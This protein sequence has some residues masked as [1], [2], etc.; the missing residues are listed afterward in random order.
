M[1]SSSAFIAA[2]I[3]GRKI[4]RITAKKAKPTDKKQCVAFYVGDVSLPT[5]VATIVALFN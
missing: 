4:L 5:V 1:V 2:F 3:A